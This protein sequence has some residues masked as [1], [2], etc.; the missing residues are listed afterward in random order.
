MLKAKRQQRK[1]RIRARISGD[2]SRPRMSVYRS[3]KYIYVQL[4]DD[5]SASTLVSAWGANPE[6]VGEEIAQK[7]VQ[8]KIEKVV[9]DRSGYQY[10]G[11]VK[12]LAD[13]ARK[14]GLKF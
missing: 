5:V 12:R 10:H 7:A 2:K 8:A 14:G 1:N 6:K 11:K 13:A 3:H 9:F 4:I